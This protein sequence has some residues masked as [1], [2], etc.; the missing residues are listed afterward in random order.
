MALKCLGEFAQPIVGVA[1]MIKAQ[2]RSPALRSNGFA[3]AKAD[4][5]L[6]GFI[7]TDAFNGKNRRQKAI[8]GFVQGVA[9]QENWLPD[10][11]LNH[12]KQI[13][14][15]LCYRYTIGQVRRVKI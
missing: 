8:H 3:L 12:D 7:Q 15:L 14:S 13:Q 5:L 2:L 4:E 9:P 11:D 1:P 6:Y 10:M